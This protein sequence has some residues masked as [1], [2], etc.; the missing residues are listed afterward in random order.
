MNLKLQLIAVT[1]NSWM[2]QLSK[3]C[4]NYIKGP[5]HATKMPGINYLTNSWHNYDV[6]L[7]YKQISN[8][9]QNHAHL[10]NKNKNQFGLD[11]KSLQ[12]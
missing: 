3:F 8:Q 1:D 2:N 12:L 9:W 11:L 7:L 4:P 5:F 6:S 10:F